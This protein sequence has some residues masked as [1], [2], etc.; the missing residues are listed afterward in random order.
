VDPREAGIWVLI[1]SALLNLDE[2]ITAR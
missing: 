1:S 2:F